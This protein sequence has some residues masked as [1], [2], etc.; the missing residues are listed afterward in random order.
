[1]IDD[2][3]KV[4]VFVVN[5]HWEVVDAALKAAGVGRVVT[6]A[7]CDTRT[8]IKAEIAAARTRISG[9]AVDSQNAPAVIGPIA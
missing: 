6:H 9:T 4:G 8:Q 3:A 1:M 5:A 2:A 7:R